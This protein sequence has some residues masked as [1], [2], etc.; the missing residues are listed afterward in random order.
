MLRESA[1]VGTARAQS[2][3]EPEAEG[4]SDQRQSLEDLIRR[5]DRADLVRILAEEHGC[6]DGGTRILR[7]EPP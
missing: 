7:R 2:P 3:L 6:I 1:A 5:L 4:S